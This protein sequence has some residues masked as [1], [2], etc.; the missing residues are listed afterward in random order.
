MYIPLAI[1][2]ARFLTTMP[3]NLIRDRRHP[4]KILK[5]AGKSL[6]TAAFPFQ[7]IPREQA[8]VNVD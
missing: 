8:N 4:Q 1:L 6:L 2:V 3:R 7:S 5:S